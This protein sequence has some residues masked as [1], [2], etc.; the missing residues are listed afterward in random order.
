MSFYTAQNLYKKETLMF[1]H[2]L[3]GLHVDH[4]VKFHNQDDDIIMDAILGSR[5]N[6]FS[7]L[8]DD[9]WTVLLITSACC[10]YSFK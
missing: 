2:F 10:I 8:D 4:F 6:S 3:E 1:E 9:L 5:I 7:T